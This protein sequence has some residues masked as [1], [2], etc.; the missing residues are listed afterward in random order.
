MWCIL[1]RYI[2]VFYGELERTRAYF[3]PLVQVEKINSRVI[4]LSVEGTVASPRTFLR[5]TAMQL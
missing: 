5:P 2:I 4:S 1:D 3:C